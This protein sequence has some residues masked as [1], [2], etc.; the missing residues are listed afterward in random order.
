MPRASSNG[1]H[2]EY[3]TFGDRDDPS[4][5]LVGGLG[6]QLVSWDDEFCQ[7]FVDRGFHVIRFDN[8]DVG[9]STKVDAPAIDLAEAVATTLGGGT[10]AAPYHLEDMATDAWGLLDALDLDRVHILGISMGGMIVQAMAIEQPE[11]V[12]SLT[13]IMSTTGDPDVGMPHPEVVAT[14]LDP[15]PQDRAGAIE[16]SVAGS[17]AIGSPDFF[18]EE[19]VRTR[20]TRSYDR[21]FHPQGVV[22]QL[23]AIVTSPSRSDQLRQLD[24]EALVI[25]GEIDPLVDVSGGVRTAECLAGSELLLLENMGHDLPQ[26]F[27]ASVISAVLAVAARGEARP[28]S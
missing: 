19:L 3:D 16:H 10:V 14:L 9:L 15:G 12:V 20:A 11:R 18:D 24:L 4:L 25:H 21:C 28:G 23:L 2:L 5:L 17:K 8:R 26:E 6:S 13:S 27:W 22:H 7:G 1:I